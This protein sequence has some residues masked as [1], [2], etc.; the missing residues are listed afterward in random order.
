MY[1]IIIGYEIIIL[2]K[3][4][5]LH[6]RLVTLDLRPR[7]GVYSSENSPFAIIRPVPP[8][9]LAEKGEADGYLQSNQAT[10]TCIY[11][12]TSHNGH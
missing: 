7:V 6:C 11:S 5:P 9:V 3:S 1:M 12:G 8:K 10:A 2:I 4:Q